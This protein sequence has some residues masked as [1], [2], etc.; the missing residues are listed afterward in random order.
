VYK[1]QDYIYFYKALEIYGETPW[2]VGVYF[3][4]HE[5]DL[6]L[7]RLL[8]AAALGI[9]ILVLAIVCGLLLA[10][11]IVRPLR[12]LA[13]ASRS[14]QRLELDSVQPLRGSLFNEL[15]VAVKAFDSMLAGLKS[16]ETYVPKTLV[17]RLMRSGD[18]S[19]GSAER[20]VTVLFTDIVD[21]TSI[22]ARLPPAQLA[23]FLNEH[24]TVLAEAIEAEEGT[25]DKYIGDSIMAF[26]GAPS[27]QPDHAAR[28]CRAARGIARLLRAE[29]ARRRAAGEEPLG[30]RIGIHSGL[31]IVGNIG[32][33]GR[34]NYTL[35]GDTVN[36]AQRLEALGK[37][38]SPD[39]DVVVLL[40]ADTRAALDD[41]GLEA[42][43]L[44]RFDLR[45]RDAPLEVY[46][47]SLP[48][49]AV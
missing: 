23:A 30:L 40:S 22:G 12:R 49:G 11:S 48:E 41:A 33:P 29:N 36:I 37:R 18:P 8:V 3:R 16:F 1:R 38:V 44:G 20:Q 39:A 15:D 47:L 9:L 24:F 21:F 45:G 6:P 46:R 28:A 10:H 5:I 4:G 13:D 27:D 19:L 26:W 31:A 14:V 17:L 42:V 35:I 32:A 25:V 43:P 34:V 7:R 2:L